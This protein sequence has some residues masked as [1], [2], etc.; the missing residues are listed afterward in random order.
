MT[1]RAIG[2]SAETSGGTTNAGD[3][4]ERNTKVTFRMMSP[5]GTK[6]GRITMN[7]KSS[8]VVVDNEEILVEVEATEDGVH[9]VSWCRKV[10]D[11]SEIGI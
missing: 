11:I 1:Q 2:A 9:D 4:T 5:H 3:E 6:R 10:V 8:R 7:L